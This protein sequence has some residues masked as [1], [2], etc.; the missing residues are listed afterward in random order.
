[1]FLLRIFTDQYQSHNLSVSV[2]QCCCHEAQYL[3]LRDYSSCC[4]IGNM[5]E[6]C[7][8]YVVSFT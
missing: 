3:G 1:M 8:F 5:I 6:L 2:P 4:K 7:H